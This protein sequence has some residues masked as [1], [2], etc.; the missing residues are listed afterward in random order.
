M[1]RTGLRPTTD[2]SAGSEQA[3]LDDMNKNYPKQQ[4]SVP[5]PAPEPPQPEPPKPPKPSKPSK[6]TP[7]PPSTPSHIKHYNPDHG[8]NDSP[9]FSD[10]IVE[11]VFGNIYPM[12]AYTIKEGKPFTPR[13]ERI[14]QKT[15]EFILGN[16][17]DTLSTTAEEFISTA[18]KSSDDVPIGIGDLATPKISGMLNFIGFGIDYSSMVNDGVSEDKAL[19]AAILHT[20]V[21][22]GVGALFANSG[23]AIGAIILLTIITNMFL[24]NIVDSI[25][26]R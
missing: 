22:I 10:E 9:F 12:G 8:E 25:I 5:H 19:T 2:G 15:T 23:L 14:E 11:E 4:Q 24:N 7:K 18:I 21:G 16:A 3:A 6:P 26:I 20:I 13:Q 1:D 17:Y